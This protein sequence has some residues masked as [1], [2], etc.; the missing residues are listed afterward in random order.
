MS[1]KKSK[2]VCP[3]KKDEE[4]YLNEAILSIGE[5]FGNLRKAEELSEAIRSWD[6]SNEVENIIQELQDLREELYG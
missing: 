1:S 3:R 5:G 4:Y 2:Y 6:Y